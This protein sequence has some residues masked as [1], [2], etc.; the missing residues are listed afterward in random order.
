MCSFFFCW[1]DGWVSSIGLS[2][3]ETLTLLTFKIEDLLAF[4]FGQELYI[5]K[6]R[7]LNLWFDKLWWYYYPIRNSLWIYLWSKV[8]CFV[9]FCS[10]EVTGPGCFRSCSCVFGKL[11]T[12]RGA[13][14]WFHD[15]WSCGAKVLE[16]WMIFS[17]K[18]NLN[19]SWKFWRN[20]ECAFGVVGKILMSRI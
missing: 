3:K 11:L 15:V 10:Y 12:R 19:H 16:Y 18:I 6:G 2:S 17:L 20:L 13:W 8:V 4:Y 5:L 14:A 1:G 9:L 7:I